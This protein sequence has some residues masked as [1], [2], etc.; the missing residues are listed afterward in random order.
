MEFSRVKRRIPRPDMMPMIDVV[1]F[2][3]IFFMLFTTIRTTPMGMDVE[4][5]RAVSGVP[6][7]SAQFE[8]SVNRDGAFYVE[9]RS[10]TGPELRAQIEQALQANPDLFVI[11]R[12]DRQVRYEHVVSALDH[13]RAVGGSKLGLAVEQES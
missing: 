7:Q 13:V 6:Q 10:V 3:L 2:L 11:I 9:G 4:L 1:F 12:A 5:P 8:I